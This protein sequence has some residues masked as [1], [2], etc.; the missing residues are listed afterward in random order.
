MPRRQRTGA[1]VG[2]PT[3]AMVLA[4]RA[5]VLQ[6][7]TAGHTKEQIGVSLSIPLERVDRYLN[8]AMDALVKHWAKPS[9]EH[10]F[11]RYA[12]FQMGIIRKLQKSY[13]Q[14]MA[15]DD[16][17]RQHG[18]CIQALK[19][20]SDIMDKVMSQGHSFGVIT[21]RRAD[22]VIN[23]SKADL[24]QELKNEIELLAGLLSKVDDHDT[25][26]RRRAAV[27]QKAGKPTNGERRYIARIRK[28]KRNSLGYVIAMPDWK[29]KKSAHQDAGGIIQETAPAPSIRATRTT[30]TATQIDIALDAP[31]HKLVSAYQEHQRKAKA[32][33]AQSTP[34]PTKNSNN[35]PRPTA[36]YDQPTDYTQEA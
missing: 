33:P 19:A 1:A 35:P 14:F 23:M 15:D 10:T 5:Q 36:G 34:A 20:Q 13:D 21:Q 31:D 12:A 17:N 26:K 11:V 28:V 24:R 2:K 4:T 6:Q 29:Y 27:L 30:Q 16:N 9:P 18:A 22:T 25:F 3:K 8:E 7:Y 32:I